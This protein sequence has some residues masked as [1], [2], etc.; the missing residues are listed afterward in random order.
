MKPIP[1]EEKLSK[2][3]E[4][5]SEEKIISKIFESYSDGGKLSDLLDSEKLIAC[6]YALGGMLADAGL[7]ANQ[8]RKVHQA[9]LNIRATTDRIKSGIYKPD[10]FGSRALVQIHNLK[11]RLA[12]AEKRQGQMEPFSKVVNLML[13]T[14]RDAEDYERLCAFVEA[15]LAYHKY[16]GGRD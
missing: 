9:L 8:L 15:V 2:E 4:L 13:D 10:E 14:I 11:Y 16:R 12:Y 1:M 6:S 3:W 5:R 7:K